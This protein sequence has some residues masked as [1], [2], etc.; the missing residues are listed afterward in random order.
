MTQTIPVI[1]P[2]AHQVLLAEALLA[3]GVTDIN[4]ID[5]T[6]TVTTTYETVFSVGENPF[7]SNNFRTPEVVNAVLD[8]FQNYDH[9]VIHDA[10][11]TCDSFVDLS[12][13][14]CE[15]FDLT[16]WSAEIGGYTVETNLRIAAQLV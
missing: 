2:T 11:N 13:S 16:H 5:G 1:T 3:S 4:N 9:I 6:L 15:Q 8:T 10:F 12:K 14:L 7:L